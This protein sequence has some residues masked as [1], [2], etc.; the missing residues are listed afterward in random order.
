MKPFN[1][2]HAKAILKPCL[3]ADEDFTIVKDDEPLEKGEIVELSRHFMLKNL[4]VFPAAKFD[5]TDVEGSNLAHWRPASAF[6]DEQDV[7]EEPMLPF[8][9]TACELAAFM[10]SGMGAAVAGHYG[11]WADG[12]DPDRLNDIPQHEN[13]ARLAVKEAYAARREA[14]KIVG[15][16]PL[17]MYVAAEHAREA[18]NKANGEANIREDVSGAKPGTEESRL[19]RDRA[20][21]SIAELEKQYE[22][23]TNAYQKEQEKW[24]NA[25][26]RELLKPAPAQTP[27]TPAPVV[28]V[29][30]ASDGPAPLPAAPNWKMRVQAEATELFLRLLAS[31]A[32]PTPHSIL[33]SMA[34]WCRDN[35]VKTD[36]NINPSANYLRTHVLGGRHW[37][38]PTMSREQ[39]KKH[40]AQVAQVAQTKVAQV[41]Q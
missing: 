3:R 37:S 31:G 8:P 29:V 41:A 32:N 40:V 35:E 12:P 14:E 38:P 18:W 11:D 6:A 20:K 7:A 17:E 27:T 26:V 16:Q 10:V 15:A 30:A 24:L 9:F 1:R 13:F 36:T 28:A 21:A 19:R 22:R 23:A 2:K 5:K 4:G 25:M 34:Q 39:A 33:D